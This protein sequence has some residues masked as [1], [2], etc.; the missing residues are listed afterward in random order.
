MFI[1]ILNLRQ[2]SHRYNSKYSTL[3]L[4]FH[5]DTL[6]ICFEYRTLPFVKIILV[7]VYL[8]LAL[9]LFKKIIL[10]VRIQCRVGRA[11]APF[12]SSS[13]LRASKRIFLCIV[14]CNFLSASTLVF[15]TG[16]LVRPPYV[17]PRSE[18]PDVASAGSR[19]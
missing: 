8:L 7:V 2:I 13:A 5:T 3:F 12:L 9:Y 17:F 10:E 18:P 6:G 16:L 11:Q 19:I 14:L 1:I 15:R 4:R